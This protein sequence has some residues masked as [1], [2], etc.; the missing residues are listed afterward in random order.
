MSVVVNLYESLIKF[1]QS[2]KENFDTFET[3]AKE[4]C[5][6]YYKHANKRA[7]KRK[8]FFDESRNEDVV[9]TE[10]EK[11]KTEGFLPILDSL[12]TNLNLRCKIYREIQ[13]NFEF[14]INLKTMTH[15][16]IIS[17]TQK[18]LLIY[19]LDLDD[20]LTNECLHFS[21]YE[22]PVDV[23]YHIDLYIYLK[24]NFLNSTFPNITTALHLF[25]TM[26]V[27]NTTSERSFSTLS[28]VKN[29]RRATMGDKRLNSLSLLAIESDI[30]NKLS[31][32]KLIDNFSDIK[33]RK[34]LL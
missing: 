4:I 12:I 13:S 24:K 19:D 30:T 16:D 2:E 1:I 23:E 9:Q 29:E 26:A 3:K 11:I 32:E 25:L 34:V 7:I 28:R 8:K 5:S 15:G 33:S 27:S 10:R 22:V 6:S 20:N 21:N 17:K 31:Y 18:L 14:L